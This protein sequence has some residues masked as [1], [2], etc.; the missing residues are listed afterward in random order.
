MSIADFNLLQY[1]CVMF[2]H[3]ILYNKH[4]THDMSKFLQRL[5]VQI[6][7]I[8]ILNVK[9]G[10]VLNQVQKCASVRYGK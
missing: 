2:S 1:K 4:Q 9:N 3:L 10:L 7:E 8:M 5:F 6:E